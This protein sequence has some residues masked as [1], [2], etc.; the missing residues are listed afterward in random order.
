[1]QHPITIRGT[2]NFI[3]KFERIERDNNID[4]VKKIISII[5]P[6]NQ[7]LFLELRYKLT[8]ILK[9]KEIGVGDPVEIEF[10]FQGSE[11]NGK[12]YNNLYVKTIKKL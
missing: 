1:M 7:K 8:K 3:G 5:T 4:I 10:I 11:K 6:D 12:R 9:I 2:L